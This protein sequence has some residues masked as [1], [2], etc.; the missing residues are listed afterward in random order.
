MEKRIYSVTQI[1]HYIAGLVEQDFMLRS[2]K[3]SGEVSNLTY[4]ASGHIYFTLKD[5]GAAMKAVMFKSKRGGLSYPMKAGDSVVVTG[6]MGVYEKG[7]TYQ[8]YVSRIE[9]AGEGELYAKVM[10]LKEE[11]SEMGM[12]DSSYK[13]PIPKYN[14]HIG[15]VTAPTGA[16]IHDIMQISAR[17]NPHVRITLYPALVQGEGAAESVVRGIETLDAMHLDTLIVGRG[18]GSL[19]D[20]MA[21]NDEEVA[22]A[23][24][25]C[26]TPVISAVGHETD[27]T[28]ADLVADLRAPTPSAAAELAVFS[29]EK[30]CRDMEEAERR[31]AFKMHHRILTEQQRL[32]LLQNRI[33]RKSPQSRLRQ[34]M[35]Q[36]VILE[37]QLNHRMQQRLNTSRQLLMQYPAKYKSLMQLKLKLSQQK[38][39]LLAARLD[40][41]SPVKKLAGGWAYVESDGKRITAASETKKGDELCL[42]FQDGKVKAVVTETTREDNHG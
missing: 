39:P 6:S 4:H 1:N 30:F 9:P 8:L 13:K 15:V 5:S 25:N 21:F 24:F 2:L 14:F 40:A 11:L 41:L 26:N 22:R 3:V 19:E 31:L 28:I 42:R 7:G 38:I 35:Q 33:L 10:R 17:R 27:T 12:F 36:A 32:S 18:G 34:L 37:E 16:A 20:L 23:I 29:Y